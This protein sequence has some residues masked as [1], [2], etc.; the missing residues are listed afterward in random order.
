MSRKFLSV[1][2]RDDQD[3]PWVLH[4]SADGR[5]YSRIGSYRTREAAMEK[6]GRICFLL[7]MYE[8]YQRTNS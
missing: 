7:D 6:L 4:F 5:T 8:E 3:L 2:Y 1:V